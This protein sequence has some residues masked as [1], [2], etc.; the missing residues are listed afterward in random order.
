[1]FFDLKNI[2]LVICQLDDIFSYSIYNA[3]TNH[4]FQSIKGGNF[5]NKPF[6]K[7][8][9][10]LRVMKNHFIMS[11]SI[12]PYKFSILNAQNYAHIKENMQAVTPH[13]MAYRQLTKIRQNLG[14]LRL[15][16]SLTKNLT[17]TL[18]ENE[19]KIS[20]LG[21]TI[22]YQYILDPSSKA[23]SYIVYQNS[24]KKQWKNYFPIANTFGTYLL[25]TS[26]HEQE[27]P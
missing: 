26:A 25:S 16:G 5:R 21:P 7:N 18:N 19:G 10:S 24:I 14:N 27:M 13:S 1:M 3:L 6:L 15:G 12:F 11:I 8:V 2:I 23:T 9:T 17:C 22:L 20:N 4:K